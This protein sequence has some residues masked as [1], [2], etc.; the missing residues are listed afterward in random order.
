MNVKMTPENIASRAVEERIN[1]IATMNFYDWALPCEDSI[2]GCRE[3][4]GRMMWRPKKEM[5]PWELLAAAVISQVVKD[6]VEAYRSRNEEWKSAIRKWF[7]QN[8]FTQAVYQRVDW[9]CRVYDKEGR[10]EWLRAKIII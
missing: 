6:Y 4:R 8:D 9:L 1:N 7:E 2:G 5:D 3:I 10:I